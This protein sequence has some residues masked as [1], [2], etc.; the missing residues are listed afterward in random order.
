MKK[1]HANA[2]PSTATGLDIYKQTWSRLLAT[3]EVQTPLGKM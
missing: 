2:L 3:Q 1:R